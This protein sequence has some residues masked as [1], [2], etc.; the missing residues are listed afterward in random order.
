MSSSPFELFRRN[1]K[2]LMVLLTLLAIFAF[3]VLPSLEVY[4]RQNA[5]L[6]GQSTT[7]ASYDGGEYDVTKV[8]YFTR[9]HYLT[10]QFLHQ[11]AEITIARGGS[12]RVSGF[13]YDTEQNAIQSLGINSSPSDQNSVLTMRFAAEAKQANL[14]LD[15]T[16]IRSWLTAFTD[17]RLSD[18]EINGVLQTATRNQL[19]QFHLY[20]QLRSQLLSEAFNRKVMAGLAVDGRPI[21]PPAQQWEL[22]LRLN[23]RAVADAYAV[24]VSEFIEQTSD[25][26]SAQEITRVYEDGKARFPDDQSPLPAFR[27]PYVANIQYLAGSLDAFI[28]REIENIS[29]EQLRAEYQRRL[30]GGDFRM[31]EQPVPPLQEQ[32]AALDPPAE[33]PATPAEPAEADAAEPADAADAADMN[34]AQA[35]PAETAAPATSEQPAAAEQPA[36]PAAVEETPAAPALETP[37]DTPAATEPA[38]PQP[39]DSQPQPSAPAPAEAPPAADT[40]AAD[41][42]SPAPAESPEPAEPAEPADAEEPAAEP[43]TDDEAPSLEGPAPTESSLL[44]PLAPQPAAVML[45][46]ARAQEEEAATETAEPA[47]QPAAA[48]TPADAT[49]AADEP[50]ADEPAAAAEEQ[51][52]AAAT[53]PASETPEQ[54]AAPER[55]QPFEEVRDQIARSLALEAASTKLEAAMGEAEKVMRTYFNELAIAGPHADR[56]PQL[57]D[58]RALAERLGL[59]YSETGLLDARQLQDQPI[60]NSFGRGEGMQRGNSFLQ[61]MYID[62]PALFSPVRTEDA[63]ARVSYVAWKIDER[64]ASIPTLE[65][66]RDEVILAIRTAEARKLARAQAE[67]LAKDFNSSEQ[68]VRELIPEERSSL[69]FESLGPFSWMNSFGFGMQPFMGNVPE[70]DNVGEAFMRQV[71]NSELNHWGVAGNA[72]ESV[73]YVVR[74]TEFSPSTDELHQRFSQLIQ[75]FQASTLAVEEVLQIRD[76]F[77]QA[78]DKRTGFRWNEEYQE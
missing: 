70:L 72:P 67:K 61:T 19:G 43:A 44:L 33:A 5:N 10:V 17:G 32:P 45:V 40:P 74:P 51:P 46:A 37:A 57:P 34:A 56:R 53:E 3:V 2:P 11:L 77:Y 78:L 59:S 39:D 23:R 41:T 31:P 49:P 69:L 35:P 73:F 13:Q 64:A 29:E 68:P 12:P 54:P 26:P 71:F 50:A 36:L 52:A 62:R 75:R 48:E 60:V 66:A 30:E 22:F 9:Q 18:A 28:D 15:D 25:R 24:N 1:L 47:D 27:R 16:A 65:E 4:M 8:S 6:G 76:G 20:E 55:T 63:P 14:D 7:L 42:D 38:A 58:L 21:V